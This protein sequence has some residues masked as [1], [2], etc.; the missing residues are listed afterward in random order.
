MPFS[1]RGL[2]RSEAAPRSAP[3][4]LASKTA[5]ESFRPVT[6]T[7]PLSAARTVCPRPLQALAW[8]WACRNGWSSRRRHLRTRFGTPGLPTRLF[9]RRKLFQSEMRPS[10]DMSEFPHALAEMGE[11]PRAPRPSALQP[12]SYGVAKNPDRQ[13]AAGAQRDG[14]RGKMSMTGNACA[15]VIALLSISK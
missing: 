6:P 14:Y 9:R 7:R 3:S 2:R 13:E 8:R 1:D 5:F 12:G 11:R 10:E 15:D 4:P